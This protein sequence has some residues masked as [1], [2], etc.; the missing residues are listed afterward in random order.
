MSNARP[1]LKL[2][3]GSL[4]LSRLAIFLGIA[5]SVVV[6]I[7]LVRGAHSDEAMLLYIASTFLILSSFICTA[8]SFSLTQ[9]AKKR[10]EARVTELLQRSGIS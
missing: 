2:L 7:N 3:K 4:I 1:A 6:L 5:A 9:I 10:Q 8:I